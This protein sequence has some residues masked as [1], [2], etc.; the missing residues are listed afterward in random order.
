MSEDEDEMN[1]LRVRLETMTPEE[2]KAESFEREIGE[3]R[4]VNRFCGKCGAAMR[5]HE[6]PAE[7]AFVCPECG[8]TVYP[9]ISPAVIVLVTK[10]DEILLQRNSH[11]RTANWSLVAEFGRILN[12]ESANC[13]AVP[14]WRGCGP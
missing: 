11:Y 6:N 10:G 3:W 9:R 1:D 2:L 7:R 4:A 14:S 12:G 13:G 5:P 8:Y